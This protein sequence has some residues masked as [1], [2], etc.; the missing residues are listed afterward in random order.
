MSFQAWLVLS[1]VVVYLCLILAFVV[2]SRRK[3]SGRFLPAT[4]SEF[5]L[6]DRKLPGWVLM[7]TYLGTFNSSLL[8][9]GIPSLA[10]QKGAIAVFE[11]W[12]SIVLGFFLALFLAKKIWQFAKD[13]GVLSPIELLSVSYGSKGLGQFAAFIFLIPLI[14]YLSMQLASLG[15]FL[16]GI[17]NGYINYIT[18]VG[19]AVFILGAYALLGGMRAIAFTDVVQVGAIYLAIAMVLIMIIYIVWPAE[20]IDWHVF[21]ATTSEHLSLQGA[22]GSFKPE[23][24]LFG[25]L[26]LC[27]VIFQPQLLSRWMMAQNESQ[28]W[29]MNLTVVGG[30]SFAFPVM[31]LIALTAY[32]IFP[33]LESANVVAP[34]MMSY[35]NDL[36][37]WGMITSALFSFGLLGAAMSTADSLMLAIAQISTRDIVRVKNKSVL[38]AK[39]LMIGALII[40]F[41]IGMNPPAII[42]DMAFYA[43]KATAALIPA[44]MALFW[45][46]R[47]A[48]AALASISAGLLTLI[49]I[50]V[51]DI[52]TYG[53]NDGF[54]TLAVSTLVYLAVAYARLVQIGGMRLQN[55]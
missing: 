13:K 24:I 1:L 27:P 17:S 44:Y 8:L 20:G 41:V 38:K 10:Y 15:I 14:S 3:K 40:A 12:A 23:F 48:L 32:I 31:I 21:K 2:K 52:D 50:V 47:N 22:Q 30:L 33:N 53:I 39:S 5:F 34:K 45:S 6:A 35:I 36:G 18:G 26:G 54:I 16:E 19:S 29:K 7:V 4:L 9:V 49:T 42:A 25:M 43:I 37:I 46:K 55:I 11:F 28:G 51:M